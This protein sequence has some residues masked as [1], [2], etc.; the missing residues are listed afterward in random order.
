MSNTKNLNRPNPEMKEKRKR[1]NRTRQYKLKILQEIEECT[2]PGGVAAIIRREGLYSSTI[3]GWRKQK[4]EGKLDKTQK[5]DSLDKILEQEKEIRRL[6]KE[7]YQTKQLIEIQKKISE[8][9]ENK[10]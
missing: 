10:N 3:S 6:K 2:I 9:I 4:I 7:L 8:L 5:S 1:K